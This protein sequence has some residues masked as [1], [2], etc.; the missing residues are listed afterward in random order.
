MTVT[1]VEEEAPGASSGDTPASSA[2]NSP[3]LKTPLSFFR[4]IGIIL[5]SDDTSGCISVSTR[6]VPEDVPVGAVRD[7]GGRLFADAVVSRLEGLG[8]LGGDT[9][10]SVEEAVV[11]AAAPLSFGSWFVGAVGAVVVVGGERLAHGLFAAEA[12]LVAVADCKLLEFER[13]DDVAGGDVAAAAKGEAPFEDGPES[14]MFSSTGRIII[15]M[16]ELT[17]FCGTC[18]IHSGTP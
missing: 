4:H 1:V 11:E 10:K 8:F 5:A 7:V 16:G 14:C 3:S 15:P 13:M 17:N 18:N 6:R 12:L 9:G 2:L